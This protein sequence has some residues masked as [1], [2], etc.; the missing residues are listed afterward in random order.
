LV[1]I[2]PKAHNKA[3]KWLVEEYP[4]VVFQKENSNET[5]VD[6]SQFQQKTK[7]NDKLKQFLQPILQQKEALKVK[8]F[9]KKMKSY[10]QALGI[11]T[12]QQSENSMN[13]GKSR[14]QQ[15]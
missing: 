12:H 11:E 9:G 3:L 8:S 10:A 5:L 15:P 14:Y 6:V 4:A 2:N 1:V 13:K 7:Y